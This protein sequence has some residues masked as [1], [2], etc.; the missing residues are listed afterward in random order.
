MNP[1][2][3]DKD[4]ATQLGTEPVGK[5]LLK[6]SLPAMVGMIVQ[7]LYNM[8]DRIFIGQGVGPLGI[9]GATVG[10]P[11]MLISMAFGMLIGIGGNSLVSISLGEGKRDY[12]E[13][14]LGNSFTLMII[15][16]GGITAL[17]LTF[18]EPILRLAGASDS[19]LPYATDYMSII[20][21]GS[22]FNGIGFG[23][24]NFIRGEG[25]PKVAMLTMLLGAVL[26]II[27]DPIFIF[28]FDMGIAGA[29]WATVISQTVSATW[30]VAY[31]LRGKSSLKLR[32]KNLVI[33]PKVMLRIFAI[34]SAPFAMQFAASIQNTILNSQLQTYGGDQAISAM[35]IM[36]SVAMLILMPLFG[37]NQGSQPIIGY[38]YGAKQY[39]RVMKTVQLAMIAATAIVFV[40]W[41]ITRFFP[42]VIVAIFGGGDPGFIALASRAM[43]LF[44]FMY[45]LIG[46]QIIASNYFQATGKPKQ[47]MFLSL[48]RQVVFLIP[49]LF[50]LPRFL[51]LDGV[52]SAGPTADF[53]S[54][55]F[56]GVLFLREAKKLRAMEHAMD[57]VKISGVDDTSLPTGP[58]VLPGK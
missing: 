15:I 44:F 55:L 28:V 48:S 27:L 26:N 54:A 39:G 19:I 49:S 45:P 56:T 34:G 36:Y 5:L 58:H 11:F 8:V 37:L 14:V 2:T 46:F 9:A 57:Q 22:V 38:N 13:K 32:K 42:G 21:W 25:N 12:A 24:N 20:L 53:L 16:M 52:Y 50:I 7:S 17:G 41:L 30:V 18:L 1:T 6:F 3:Q 10:F 40:G 29:A 43:F 31:Y 4:R 47:A 35:G 33:E 51:G 23:L